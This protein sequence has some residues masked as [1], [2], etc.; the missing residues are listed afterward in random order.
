MN[1]RLSLPVALLLLVATL[2]LFTPSIGF[3]DDFLTDDNGEYPVSIS[4]QLKDRASQEYTVILPEFYI[5]IGNHKIT[6]AWG[7]NYSV[8]LGTASDSFTWN[9][10]RALQRVNVSIPGVYT[11]NVF[12]G[13]E[14][15]GTTLH[16]YAY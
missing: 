6:S 8:P 4:F 11:G 2:S 9:S 5:K 1:K 7:S 14:M 12:L 16:T 3:A 13:A 10:T 15:Q